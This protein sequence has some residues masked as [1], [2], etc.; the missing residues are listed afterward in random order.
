[1]QRLGQALVLSCRLW[2]AALS[3]LGTLFT[4]TPA[5]AQGSSREQASKAEIRIGL[6]TRA[7]ATEPSYDPNAPPEDDAIAGARLALRDNNGTGAFTGQRY[8]LE[9]AILEEGRSAAEAAR[10]LAARGTGFVVV[11]LP[12]DEVLAVADALKSDPVVIFNA[13]APD[14]RL[15]GLDC[16]A[17]LFHVAPSRAMLADGLAQFLAFM[18]WR[19][20]F[21]I[22]GPKPADRL[23]ADA[24]KRAARKFGLQ[25]AA[26]KPWEFG[27]LARARGDSPT[28]AEAFV[29]TRGIDYD[30]A[31]VADEAG[32]FGDY[33]PFRTVDPRPVA[34]TQGLTVTTWS[35]VLE[36]WGAAQAQNRFR[37]LAKRTMTPLDHQVW[38]AM[39]A[40]G[41]AV[42]LMKNADPQAVAAYLKSPAFALPAY[43]GVPLSFRPWDRQLR[44]PL[45]LVQPRALVTVAPE[46]GF[47]HQRTPLDTLGID[48]PESECKVQ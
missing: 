21:L 25:I 18:R 44:Q 41:E 46:K 38:M 3:V 29:F 37:R 47:L 35:P 8:A 45:L 27:A 43:K 34:G 10:A 1:M 32:D 36:V 42:T 4:G 40:V 16:R 14:D 11:N 2:P 28:T 12:A 39:R 19:K 26:E 15:R 24:V 6:I 7:P 5:M 13:G 33:I 48:Q 22:V 31:I 20:L 9:E 23:Y 17:N 30:I